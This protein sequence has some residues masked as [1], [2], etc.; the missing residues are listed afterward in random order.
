MAL[1]ALALAIWAFRSPYD[2][3]ARAPREQLDLVAL[4]V[5][6]PGQPV[7]VVEVKDGFVVGRGR[8]CGI[9]FDDATVSKMHIRLHLD[10]GAATIEDLDSTNGTL[11]NGKRLEGMVA[12]RQ[13][14]RIGLGSNQI[15]Y[16][17]APLEGGA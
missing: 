11:L 1:G 7:E 15:V 6:R 3:G 9:V 14:D 8:E 16:L 10:A 13:G 2:S 4:Q 5:L 12:L 17:G